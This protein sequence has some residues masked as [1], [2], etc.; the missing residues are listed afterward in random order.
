MAILQ[1]CRLLKGQIGQNTI[2]RKTTIIHSPISMSLKLSIHPPTLTFPFV[3]VDT[4]FHLPSCG[5]NIGPPAQGVRFNSKL[6][7]HATTEGETEGAGCSAKGFSGQRVTEEGQDTNRLWG[8]KPWAIEQQQRIDPRSQARTSYTQPS[9][10]GGARLLG[11]AA[12]IPSQLATVSADDVR[13]RDEEGDERDSEDPIQPP[14]PAV[15]RFKWLPSRRARA[16]TLQRMEIQKLQHEFEEKDFAEMER[17]EIAEGPKNNNHTNRPTAEEPKRLVGRPPGSDWPADGTGTGMQFIHEGDQNEKQGHHQHDTQHKAT[18]PKKHKKKTSHKKHP[19]DEDAPKRKGKMDI[20]KLEERLA[21]QKDNPAPTMSVDPITGE[22]RRLLKCTLCMAY[23]SLKVCAK[24]MCS[25]CCPVGGNP[26]DAHAQRQ[27]KMEAL[28]EAGIVAPASQAGGAPSPLGSAPTGGSYPSPVSGPIPNQAA[29]KNK[30]RKSN[31]ADV[32]KKA[33]PSPSFD[34]PERSKRR[35]T[36]SPTPSMEGSEFPRVLMTSAPPQPHHINFNISDNS[37]SNNSAP[38]AATA[39][40]V[41]D[42]IQTEGIEIEESSAPPYPPSSE[43]SAGPPP[44]EAPDLDESAKANQK[45][46][47]LCHSNNY[48]KIC[49]KEMCRVCC[50]KN[51]IPCNSHLFQETLKKNAELSKTRREQDRRPVKLDK[52]GRRIPL[53]CSKCTAY[54]AM[55][56]CARDLCSVCCRKDPGG[57]CDAHAFIFNK[58][59]KANKSPGGGGGE[60]GNNAATSPRNYSDRRK[61]KKNKHSTEG[62]DASPSASQQRGDGMNLDGDEDYVDASEAGGRSQ[63]AKRRWTE[64][65]RYNRSE[66]EEGEGDLPQMKTMMNSEREENGGHIMSPGFQQ[67][68]QQRGASTVRCCDC[69]VNAALRMC[70]KGMCSLCCPK[71]G[72]PCFAHQGRLGIPPQNT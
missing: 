66:E 41:A 7:S 56:D 40:I 11:G 8:R 4:D 30:K 45:K 17:E 58:T 60:D 34:D 62:T 46:C 23:N 14:Q 36:E 57:M 22:K 16:N 13:R 33:A 28:R 50:P 64:M 18:K 31:D 44:L 72:T 2:Y 27:R 10:Y 68:Q 42:G 37:N 15:P 65:P 43:G 49:P 67:Q 39:I 53:K 19:P 25:R 38:T 70:A 52:N 48:L 54:N 51:G 9:G 5:K 24:G 61:L 69:N 6:S 29:R 55:K 32:L 71:A 1:V 20:A 47:T 21:K 26:C 12:S 3:D 63:P 59:Q 35:R